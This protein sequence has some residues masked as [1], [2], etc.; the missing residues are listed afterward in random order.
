MALLW[1]LREGSGIR[2]NINFIHR[3]Q[4]FPKK[5]TAL[6]WYSYLS[7]LD[8]Q[9]MSV[10]WHIFN[11]GV[12][13][14]HHSTASVLKA[15]ISA[16]NYFLSHSACCNYFR[17]KLIERAEQ[18][19]YIYLY[20][21]CSLMLVIVSFHKPINIASRHSSQPSLMICISLHGWMDS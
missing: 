12:S 19:Q 18:K 20:C 13:F 3:F 1:V 8:F 4:S 11:S 5:T 16:A 14:F 9:K 21:G 15:N 7:V 2:I 6:Q 10:V 17:N